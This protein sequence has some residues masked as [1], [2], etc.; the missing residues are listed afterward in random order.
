MGSEAAAG[1]LVYRCININ[2]ERIKCHLYDKLIAE[3]YQRYKK[4]VGIKD[5]EE[6]LED[7]VDRLLSSNTAQ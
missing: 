7:T 1:A 6:N 2:G 4:K 3:E 5:D